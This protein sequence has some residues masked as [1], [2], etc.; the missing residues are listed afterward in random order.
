ME[1][2]T[3]DSRDECVWL[4][5]DKE[6]SASGVTY[7]EAGLKAKSCIAKHGGTGRDTNADAISCF[8]PTGKAKHSQTKFGAYLFINKSR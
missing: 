6:A 3:T 8:M 4:V 5:Q 2:G 7:A 1:L